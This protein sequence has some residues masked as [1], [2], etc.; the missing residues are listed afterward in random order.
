MDV[1]QKV[2]NVSVFVRKIRA[3]GLLEGPFKLVGRSTIQAMF[4]EIGAVLLLALF[5]AVLNTLYGGTRN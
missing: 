5:L 3:I 1:V 4:V 2:V